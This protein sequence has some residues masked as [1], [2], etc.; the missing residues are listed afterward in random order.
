MVVLFFEALEPVHAGERAAAGEIVVTLFRQLVHIHQRVADKN[1]LVL[2]AEILQQPLGRNAVL[3]VHPRVGV[4]ARVDAVVEVVDVQLLEV[5]GLPRRLKEH[6]AELRV[7]A[8]RAARVHQH[9]H[10]D[11]VA[12]RALVAHLERARVVAGVADG[13]IHVELR[14]VAERLV[15]ILPQQAESHLELADVERIVAAEIAVLSLSRDLKGAAVNAL[16][17]DADALR[18]VAG[19]AEV[20][21]AARADPVRAAIVLLLLFLETLLKHLENL[22]DALFRIA[23]LAQ[24]GAELLKRV[25]RVVEPVHQLVRQ[26]LLGEGHVLEILQKRGVKLVVV[27]LALDE[28]GAAEV[29]KARQR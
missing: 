9:Q 8:H 25:F 21:V 20:G 24:K 3:A 4:D 14:L 1:D 16:A 26:Q 11:G 7:V 22:V 29:V 28:H 5:V 12:P 13:A 18:A 6:R 27:R 17:A 15:G 23:L 2:A 19:V 10:L